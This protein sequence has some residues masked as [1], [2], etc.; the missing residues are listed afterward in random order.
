MLQGSA[1]VL[2]CCFALQLV[3]GRCMLLRAPSAEDATRWTDGLC[4]AV[5]IVRHTNPLSREAVAAARVTV[6][7]AD[8]EQ[9]DS[10]GA[11]AQAS[12][13][14]PHGRFEPH[15]ASPSPG[16]GFRSV[17]GARPPPLDGANVSDRAHVALAMPGPAMLT[18]RAGAGT[19]SHRPRDGVA[20]SRGAGAPAPNGG[21]NGTPSRLATGAAAVT[22]RL[23]G[24]GNGAS[25]GSSSS[26][27]AASGF[28]GMSEAEGEAFSRARHGKGKELEEML[29]DGTVDPRIRD[30]AGNTL[31]HTA[32]QNNAR[33]AAKAV[34]R[35][36]DYAIS[37][38]VL[39]FIDA[40]NA[41][42]NTALHYCFAYGYTALGEYLLSLGADERIA[43][44]HGLCCYEGLDPNAP[45]PAALQTTAMRAGRDRVAT[46]RAYAQQRAAR[47]ERSSVATQQHMQPQPGAPFWTGPGGPGYGPGGV[48]IAAQPP[49]M[50]GGQWV[51]QA[52]PAM[53]MYPPWPYG[54]P[55]AMMPM[56]PQQVQQQQHAAAP[57]PARTRRSG[58]KP[59]R[60]RM[61][62]DAAMVE[63][64]RAQL[65]QHRSRSASSRSSRGTRDGDSSSGSSSDEGHGSMYFGRRVPPPALSSSDA[66]SAGSGPDSGG[67][68]GSRRRAAAS[69]RDD[70]SPLVED[71]PGMHYARACAAEA[72]AAAVWRDRT[73][74][75]GVAGGQNGDGGS[76]TEDDDSLLGSPAPTVHKPEWRNNSLYGSSVGGVNA[77]ANSL[78]HMQ[79]GAHAQSTSPVHSGVAALCAAAAAWRA[80]CTEVLECAHLW[81]LLDIARN[82]AGLL[83]G[84]SDTESA[85]TAA[86]ALV[87]QPPLLA[88]LASTLMGDGGDGAALTR[89]G[90]R[91]PL[92]AASARTGADSTGLLNALARVRRDESVAPHELDRA[93]SSMDGARAASVALLRRLG[94]NDGYLP[95]GD[96]ALIVA[97]DALR[98][99]YA[100]CSALA[101]S[102]QS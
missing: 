40:Q 93:A 42:G 53:G 38:P 30:A 86:N 58:S 20:A 32:A 41:A 78:A 6:L 44:V 68:G 62:A 95:E 97:G 33:R 26:A 22:Q 71:T 11:E 36:T 14:P 13:V 2:D 83:C 24:T 61:P 60:Q 55:P 99:L 69:R 102:H 57:A 19:A 18:P 27:A 91:L 94:N 74:Y 82:L 25:A 101:K 89:V 4:T 85:L 10:S 100:F 54:P 84:H 47:A 3:D 79:L 63:A 80:R 67:S 45:L 12:H 76:S 52:A 48:M 92:L 15:S 59:R 96:E 98:T 66:S 17:P 73:A 39:E 87:E 72:A 75:A 49:Q 31:L 46:A 90:D 21:T 43:N 37:P 1:D 28:F 81:Q 51:Y 35:C 64:L 8:D 88:V 9:G 23:R 77:A 50:A 70:N 34:L 16:F 65:G 5:E 7:T 29:L 56:P